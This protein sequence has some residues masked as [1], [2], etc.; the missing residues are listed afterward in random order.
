[1]TTKVTQETPRTFSEFIEIVEREQGNCGSSGQLWFRGAGKSSYGLIPTLYRHPMHR[2]VQSLE[3]LEQKLIVRFRQRS[4]P[5]VT[6]S[7]KDQWDMLFFMQHYGVPTRLLD[8]TESPMVAL[9][10]AVMSG[11]FKI[12]NGLPVYSSDAA[13]WILNPAVWNSSALKHQSYDRGILTP[14]DEALAGYKPGTKFKDMNMHPVALYGAHNS[15][16]IVA[17]RG[18]FTVFGQSNR[19]MEKVFEAEHFP[20]GSLLKLV[21]ERDALPAMR[22]S[23]LNQGISES[24]VFP[25]LE[26]LAKEI[27]RSFAF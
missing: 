22:L 11:P 21:L 17:Q 25:D 12:T 5:F 4:I 6:E 9:F 20:K 23:I 1:M 19:P 24:V 14:V 3:E 7:P 10:F 8:W 26:N 2:S 18:A 16:R 13:I 27:K 15:P